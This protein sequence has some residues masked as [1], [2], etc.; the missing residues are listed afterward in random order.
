MATTPAAGTLNRPVYPQA[1]AQHQ[2]LRSSLA[3]V[4]R[5]SLN[6]SC[7][8]S[9]RLLGNVSSDKVL[10]QFRSVHTSLSSE[11]QFGIAAS[12][13]LR[14]IGVATTPEALTGLVPGDKRLDVLHQLADLVM[15]VRRVVGVLRPE[16]R[17]IHLLT[18]LIVLHQLADLVVQIRRVAGLLWG[19]IG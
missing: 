6:R 3:A 10:N 18:D 11:E 17:A 19:W 7:L 16:A 15:Q 8:L 9:F 4:V 14:F 1:A 2:R 12:N 13:A 5:T